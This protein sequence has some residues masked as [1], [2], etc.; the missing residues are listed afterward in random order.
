M[1]AVPASLT[2]VFAVVA[3]LATAE[4]IN[5]VASFEPVE[6]HCVVFVVDQNRTVS[7]LPPNQPVFR[8]GPMLRH[9]PRR[10]FRWCHRSRPMS[11]AAVSKCRVSRWVPTMTVPTDRG[12]R[13]VWSDRPVQAGTG[14]LRAPG[15]TGSPPPITVVSVSDTGI[16]PTR[17][18]PRRTLTGPEPYTI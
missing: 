2:L 16:C 17:L 5:S 15:T 4:T 8:L 14:T 10:G 3:G 7:W 6:T 1:F 9:G 12:R 18:V 13:S 11:R